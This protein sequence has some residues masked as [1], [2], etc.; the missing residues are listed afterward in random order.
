VS[1]DVSHSCTLTGVV[2]IAWDVVAMR[3]GCES[4]SGT[5]RARRGW[6]VSELSADDGGV[7]RQERGVRAP[8]AARA[9]ARRYAGCMVRKWAA[10]GC[11]RTRLFVVQSV[12]LACTDYCWPRC[13]CHSD[14]AQDDAKE[15]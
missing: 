6:L 5:R 10:E 13:I 8:D 7:E 12:V 1:S 3:V 11:L 2:N 14:Y 15:E 4:I 9:A